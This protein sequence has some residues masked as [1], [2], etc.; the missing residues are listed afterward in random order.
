MGRYV[1]DLAS[2][3]PRDR[4]WVF[5][6]SD[7]SIKNHSR[8]RPVLHRWLRNISFSVWLHQNLDATIEKYN[9]DCINVQCG[10]GGLFLLKKQNI[11]VIA[12]CHHTWWQQ[13]RYVPG[14][15]WKKVFIPFERH[16]YKIADKIVCDSADIKDVLITKY[17][18]SPEKIAVVPIGVDLNRFYPDKKIETIPNSAL[19]IG[20][21]DKRKGVDF[22]LQAMPLLVQK[23]PD[24]KLFIGGTGRLGSDLRRYVEKWKLGEHVEFLGFIPDDQ[25][26][27]WYNR[28]SCV[29]VPSIFE[30]F[31]LTVIEAMA[32]GTTVIAT[33]VD[34]VKNL[35]EHGVDGLLVE[36]GD[37]DSLCRRLVEVV[38][39]EALRME[40][41]NR[42]LDKI[43]S[44]YTWECSLRLFEQELQNVGL[45]WR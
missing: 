33:N 40:Y 2:Q 6:S 39:D 22:L 43:K 7:A 1:Y 34:S 27:G 17:S 13:S 42:A 15:S 32:A 11:P 28:V 37:V 20:R 14:Q 41:E 36:Y 44:S 35:V 3:L 45:N 9:L 10:P 23:V 4:T 12:T 29:V 19:F 18:L 5:S 31:G 21:L 38:T 26:N 8:V 25:L 24:M 16:T 30:G